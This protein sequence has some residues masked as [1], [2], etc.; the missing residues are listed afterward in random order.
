M[1]TIGCPRY[2]GCTRLP[3]AC[4]GTPVAAALVPTEQRCG[5]NSPWPTY[6]RRPWEGPLPEV[7]AGEDIPRWYVWWRLFDLQGGRCACCD[8]SPAGI[9]HDHRTGALRGLLCVSCNLLEGQYF[10]RER[11]CVHPG[12][13]C[14][15]DYW[16]NP[17]A[18]PFGWLWVSSAKFRHADR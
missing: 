4:L 16:R 3:P 8:A 12:P 18:R 5:G 6:V 17:P 10:R 13:H 15:V 2:R 7:W 1:S 9:D 14:F 11:M